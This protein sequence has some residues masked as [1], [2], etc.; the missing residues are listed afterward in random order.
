[1]NVPEPRFYLKQ[2]KATSET[3]ICMQV[4]YCGER[5]FI[6]TGEKVLPTYWDFNKQRVI[7]SR[8]NLSASTTNMFLDKIVT[9]FKNVFRCLLV[10]TDIPNAKIVTDKLLEKIDSDYVAKKEDNLK[11][12][13]ITFFKFISNF[14]E[15]SRSIKSLETVKTYST[16][17]NHLKLFAKLKNTNEFDFKD[18]TIEWRNGFYK[19]LQDKDSSINTIAK[20]I[21]NIKVFLN[22]AVERGLNDNLQFRSKKFCKPSENVDKVFLSRSELQR[23]VELDLSNDRR[24]DIVRDYFIISC[25]TSLRYSDFI[26]IKPD[27]IKESTIEIQTNKTGQFVIIPISNTVRRVLTKYNNNLPKAPCNQIFNTLLKDIC[28]RAD[29]T[30][31]ITITK[32]KRGKKESKTYKKYELVSCHTGRRTMIS[33]AILEGI[34]T[35]SIMLISAHKSLRVFQRYVQITAKEN[36]EALLSTNFFK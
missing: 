5:I 28:R 11:K 8:K 9:E 1:M 6:S 14:I 7:I 17:L 12:E 24:L 3:L 35:S 26:N 22:E 19:Y 27:N 15:E 29:I 36:A 32:I 20:H 21:K 10:T 25:F 31:K 16:T 2:P 18:I 34:S 23:L 13:S 4:K 33:N 30:E